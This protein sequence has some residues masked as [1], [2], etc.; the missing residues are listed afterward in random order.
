ML[1]LALQAHLISKTQ[2]T[3]IA[4][5]RIWWQGPDPQNAELPDVSF[6]LDTPHKATHDGNAEDLQFSVVT[7]EARTLEPSPCITLAGLIRRALR[8]LKNGAT[9]S[10]SAGDVVVEQLCP[11]A[12]DD[13]TTHYRADGTERTVYTRT[14]ICRVGYRHSN[15]TV[16]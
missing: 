10:T 11:I 6:T 16:T 1:E 8:E 7:F 2:I 4:G 15:A 13:H 9:V 5:E 3:A 12:V 14:F